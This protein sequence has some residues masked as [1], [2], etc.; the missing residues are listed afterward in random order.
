MLLDE[1][2]PEAGGVE[3]SAL[4]DFK[5]QFRGK[6]GAERG[7]VLLVRPDGYVAFHHKGFDP[8]TLSAALAPWVERSPARTPVPT[9]SG[10]QQDRGEGHPDVHEAHADGGGKM[11]AADQRRRRTPPRMS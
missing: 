1:G 8:R 7:S 6:L 2:V 3:A 10:R 4:V 9:A 5:G 11:A